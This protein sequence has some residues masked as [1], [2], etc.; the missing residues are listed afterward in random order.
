M[1]NRKRFVV[2]SGREG[3][4]RLVRGPDEGHFVSVRVDENT[5]LLVVNASRANT[6]LQLNHSR[7]HKL[8][9]ENRC[10]HV[11][12]LQLVQLPVQS[13]PYEPPLV[14]RELLWRQR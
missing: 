5:K 8:A 9:K 7:C 3:G 11:D 10:R 13:V 2:P 14:S 12:G 4:F 6:E 1:E